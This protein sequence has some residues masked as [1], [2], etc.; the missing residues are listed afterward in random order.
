MIWENEFREMLRH[1]ERLL[2][3]YRK[4]GTFEYLAKELGCDERKPYITINYSEFVMIV[5]N[6]KESI[7]IADISS[8]VA[9]IILWYNKEEKKHN[10]IAHNATITNVS[11]K[12]NAISTWLG[13][14][15]YDDC[16]IKNDDGYKV[17]SEMVKLI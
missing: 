4:N 12:M 11:Y 10:L 7:F 2:E 17:N 9:F 3:Y 16:H 1:P 8:P 15:I 13:T 5:P 14:S 6:E